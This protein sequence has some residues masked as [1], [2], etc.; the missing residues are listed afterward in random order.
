M[1][2]NRK[3][4]DV[5]SNQIRINL[6]NDF[7]AKKVEI[8][9]LPVEE[10]LDEGQELQDLLLDAPILTN[11]ELKKYGII[12]DWISQWNVDEF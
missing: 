11:D 5:N 3:T 9:I 6:P 4:Q 7:H 10:S 1:I 2:S 8:I 12:R